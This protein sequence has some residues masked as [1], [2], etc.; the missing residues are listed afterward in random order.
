MRATSSLAHLTNDSITPRTI[1]II[2]GHPEECTAIACKLAIVD[3]LEI[4]HYLGCLGG[5]GI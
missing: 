3:G 2:R 1:G 5:V 4:G